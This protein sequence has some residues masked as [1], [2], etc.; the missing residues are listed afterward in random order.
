MSAKYVEKGLGP[1]QRAKGPLFSANQLMS[2]S[3]WLC[4][5]K[6]QGVIARTRTF[7]SCQ[8]CV[9]FLERLAG[10]LAGYL[11]GFP[12]QLGSWHQDRIVSSKPFI[13]LFSLMGQ[14]GFRAFNVTACRSLFSDVFSGCTVQQISPCIWPGP[15]KRSVLWQYSSFQELLG[16]YVL[17]S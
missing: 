2:W 9:R 12:A 5:R 4:L 6:V 8:S 17:C 10:S 1:Q 7:T 16:F 11:V 13:S 14:F 3:T 15:Q